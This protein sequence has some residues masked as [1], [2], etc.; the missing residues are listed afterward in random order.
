[1]RIATWNVGGLR[2]AVRKGFLS[3]VRR[4]RP[5]V[6]LLQEVRALPEQLPPNI[7][8]DC[9]PS[10]VTT[11]NNAL[12]ATCRSTSRGP[13]MPRARAARTKSWLHSS[14]IPSRISRR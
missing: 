9:S 13:A 6:L 11:G 4:V 2:A 3:D 7:A 5:D 12:R 14:A 10:M 1:M 8:A